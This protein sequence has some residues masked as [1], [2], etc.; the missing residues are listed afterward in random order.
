MTN[1]VGEFRWRIVVRRAKHLLLVAMPLLIALSACQ[2]PLPGNDAH[3]DDPPPPPLVIAAPCELADRIDVS[4]VPLGEVA[5]H[6]ECDPANYPP[7]VP[8]QQA[9]PV[10]YFVDFVDQD[11]E[12]GLRQQTLDA[13][14]ETDLSP[15]LVTYGLFCDNSIEFAGGSGWGSQVDDGFD[16]RLLKV[17]C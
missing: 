12:H 5:V 1:G 10:F 15:D 8:G 16:L 13:I 3:D 2:V 17:A 11:Q 9:I 4:N 14:A 6:V 7:P